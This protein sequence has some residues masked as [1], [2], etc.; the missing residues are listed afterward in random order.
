MTFLILARIGESSLPLVYSVVKEMQRG[1]FPLCLSRLR[2]PCCLCEDGGL[3]PSLTQWV[4]DLALPQDTLRHTLQMRLASAVA[5]AVVYVGH[6]C[7]SD[8]TPGLGT[9]ICC[10]MALKRKK[11]MQYAN[12]CR[13]FF[14]FFLV[15]LPFLEPLPRHMEVTRLGV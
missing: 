5:V 15:F 7:I 2:T 12:Y 4:K 9:S 8:S 6:S 3:T 11:E 13:L 14:F 1:E 10:G